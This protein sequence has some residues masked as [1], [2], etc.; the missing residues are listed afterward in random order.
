MASLANSWNISL[1]ESLV[2]IDDIQ[3]MCAIGSCMDPPDAPLGN[4]EC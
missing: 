3:I 1:D 2:D 4:P